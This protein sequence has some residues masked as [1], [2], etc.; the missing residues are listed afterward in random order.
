MRLTRRCASRAG[1]E[2]RT[3]MTVEAVTQ[4]QC[5]TAHAPEGMGLRLLIDDA[6]RCWTRHAAPAVAGGR[7]LTRGFSADIV[8]IQAGDLK[9]A[10]KA[11]AAARQ[12]AKSQGRA[13]S[14][15]LDIEVLIEDEATQAW[16][17]LGELEQSPASPHQP[18]SLMYI[19]T[20]RGLVSLLADIQVLDI[21]DGATLLTLSA[22]GEHRIVSQV[23]PLLTRRNVVAALPAS[24]DAALAR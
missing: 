19:G 11:C 22:R 6:A 23:M 10:A 1:L 18:S 21:A 14:V 16:R 5:G 8:R 24:A 2:R 12:S 15:L 9:Q 4:E 7:E 20:A 3:A 17:Y 13:V